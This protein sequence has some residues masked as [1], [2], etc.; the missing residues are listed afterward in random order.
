MHRW[1][2]SLVFLSLTFIIW[3][4]VWQSLFL[5]IDAWTTLDY[6]LVTKGTK[7]VQAEHKELEK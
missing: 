2:H 4:G 3:P 1:E 6:L 7:R 5:S